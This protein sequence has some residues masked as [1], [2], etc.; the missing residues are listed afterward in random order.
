M[1]LHTTR[2]SEHWTSFSYLLSCAIGLFVSGALQVRVVIV[3][4]IIPFE[5]YI[6]IKISSGNFS[7]GTISLINISTISSGYTVELTLLQER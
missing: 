4:V 2:S 5:T 3:I 1:T 6:P 7:Q